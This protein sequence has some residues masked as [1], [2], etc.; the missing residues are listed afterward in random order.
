[1]ATLLGV[2]LRWLAAD[3]DDA[4]RR[5]HDAVGVDAIHFERC[6]PK[7]GLTPRRRARNA[8]GQKDRVQKQRRQ[9]DVVEVAAFERF[10]ALAQLAADA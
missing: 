5:I 7:A 9:V 4:A 1:M 8:D 10:K 6:D 3:Q 2:G